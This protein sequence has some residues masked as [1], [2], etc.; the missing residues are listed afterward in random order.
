M[1]EPIRAILLHDQEY[2]VS[3]LAGLLQRQGIAARRARSCQE[4]AELLAG[5]PARYVIFTDVNLLDGSW[6]DVLQLAMSTTEPAVVVVVARVVDIKFYVEV[7]ERGAFD[8]VAPP[9]TDSDVSHVLRCATT[10]LAP[11]CIRAGA[12]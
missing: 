8:F 10:A 3:L 4:A 1:T 11:S 12:A 6:A 9:F 2:P 7:I 5:A